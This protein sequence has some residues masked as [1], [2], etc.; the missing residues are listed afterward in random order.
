M[1]R[2]STEKLNGLVDDLLDL[3]RLAKGKL[4]MATEDEPRRVPRDGG[5]LP[6]RRG[7]AWPGGRRRDAAGDRAPARGSGPRRPGARTC[8]RTRSSSRRRTASSACGCSARR[9]C[10]ACSGSR[11][12]TRR[13]DLRARPR[14]HLREVR[15]GA[16]RPQPARARH[17]PRASIRRGIVEAHGGAIWAES[18]G[19]GVRFVVVLPE[20]APPARPERARSRG[21]AAR[22]RRRRAGRGDARARRARGPRHALPRHE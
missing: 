13:G 20:E 8:S 10:P 16:Q 5:A 14:A 3:A 2:E 9:R 19:D 6:A 4:E 21:R 18:P 12:G 15:A 17:R 1:A 7:A 22:P 11:C